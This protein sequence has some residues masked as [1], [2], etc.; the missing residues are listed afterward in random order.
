MDQRRAR[1]EARAKLGKLALAERREE[2]VEFLG[3]DELQYRV[4][5]KL[6][7]LVVEVGPLAFVSEAGMG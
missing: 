6:E 1:D 2:P 4:P 7:A 3:E 5:E